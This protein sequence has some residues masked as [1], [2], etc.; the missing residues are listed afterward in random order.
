MFIVIN[1]LYNYFLIFKQIIRHYIAKRNML[2]VVQEQNLN[3]SAVTIFFWLEQLLK[4]LDDFPALLNFCRITWWIP[5]SFS[6]GN[7]LKTQ[8]KKEVSI[9]KLL[10]VAIE[11]LL[12]NWRIYC[13]LSAVCLSLFIELSVKRWVIK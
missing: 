4:V 2:Q 6:S 8:S 5:L 1:L 9:N 13:S 3:I 11:M 7:E 12:I 10:R